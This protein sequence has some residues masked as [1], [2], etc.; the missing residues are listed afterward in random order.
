MFR[1]TTALFVVSSALLAA[2]CVSSDS[3]LSSK[4]SDADA[5]QANLS[6]GIGYLRQKRMELAEEKLVK[7]IEQDPNLTDAH[8]ALALVYDTQGETKLAEKHYRRTIRLAPDDP[9]GQNAYAVFLCRRDRP[10]DAE[11]Y[12]NNAANNPRY[13]TPWAALANAGVCWRQAGNFEKAEEYFRKA[14]QRNGRYAEALYQLTDLTFKTENYLQS[15]AFLQR[16]LATAPAT[17][18]ALWLGVQIENELGDAQAANA[19][20]EQ[21]KELFPESQEFGRYLE[22][23]RSGGS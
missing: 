20:G 3:S 12:F 21:L 22:L 1:L 14:L 9:A 7:A 5:A 10:A 16:Y 8:S 11:P 6:L 13:A 4:A 18:S 2:G 23:E 19:Y 17:P 15:R